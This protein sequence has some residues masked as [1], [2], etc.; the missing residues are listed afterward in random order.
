LELPF[1]GRAA[2]AAV[3]DGLWTG[4]DAVSTGRE[5]DKHIWGSSD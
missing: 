2:V 4:T 1:S 5:G 3:P